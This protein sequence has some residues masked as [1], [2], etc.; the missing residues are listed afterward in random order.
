AL[1]LDAYQGTADY[2]GED[3]EAS[4]RQAE[5]YFNGKQGGPA[6]LEASVIAW[7]GDAPVGACLVCEWTERG[8]PVVAF[9]ATRADSKRA[10][11]GRLLLAV[12]TRRLSRA[13]HPELLAVITRGNAPS[14]A[15]FKSL[16]FEVNGP[17]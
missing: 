1:L 10:G 12:A 15:L 14:E 11:V 9:V 17:R 4:F 6:M 13:G 8:R 2:E 5:R 16:G 7:R 3:L